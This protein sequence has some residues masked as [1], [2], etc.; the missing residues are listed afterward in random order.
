MLGGRKNMVNHVFRKGLVIG[1]IFLFVGAGSITSIKGTFDSKDVN[2]ENFQKTNNIK[3]LNSFHKETPLLYHRNILKGN[4]EGPHQNMIF[5]TKEWWYYNAYLNDENCELK[6]WFVLM[7]IQLYPGFGGLK[8]EL[9]DDEN[10]S[11]GGDDFIGLDKIHAYG[12]GVNIFFNNS[13]FEIG[14]YP[15]WHIYGEYTKPDEPEIIV[16]LTFKANSL[17]MWLIKNTG[18]NRSNSFFGYYCVMNCSVYGNISLN[19]TI[20]NVSGL[21]YHDHTWAPDKSKNLK[22]KTSENIKNWKEN[23]LI[24]LLSIW[25][26]LCIH[27]DNGW[28]MFVGKIY[29]ENRY[30]SSKFG[31]GNLCFTTSGVKFYEIYFFLMD[32]V[33]T[34]HHPIL[35]IEIPTKVHIK[36]LFFNTLGLKH[37]KGPILLDFYYEEKNNREELYGNPTNYGYW[38]SQGKTYG[39]AKSLGITIPLNGWAVMETTIEI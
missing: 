12:P 39:S 11:Y 28:D 33:E 14:R 25:D 8:L 37:I 32:Y 18:H 17:P 38:I 7:S 1:I 24:N 21:G 3:N 16:N 20:Y 29:S 36:A 6:N 10:E 13:A 19:G 27:F 30:L 34:K 4:D 31:P 5:P 15:N 2:N 26:W 35:N 22:F 9:F 23:K